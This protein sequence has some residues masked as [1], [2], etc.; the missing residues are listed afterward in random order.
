M[1]IKENREKK[2]SE[3]QSF[4]RK[5]F[6]LLESAFLL[7]AV[8]FSGNHSLKWGHPLKQKQ[9]LLVEV[10]PFNQ[11]YSF[12]VE[13]I[14]FRGSPCFQWKPLLLVEDILLVKTIPFIG[15]HYFKRK[16]FCLLDAIPFSGNHVFQ[17]KL[18][19]LVEAISFIRNR[20]IS[21]KRNH[22][23]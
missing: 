2:T 10:I 3:D 1:A 4:Q 13:A 15:S 16:L 14:L 5:L 6:L 18:F 9:F 21:F 22:S 23:F 11:R 17:W 12:L 7:E 19:L 20:F 8:P